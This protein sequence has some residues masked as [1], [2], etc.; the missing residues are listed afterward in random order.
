MFSN[1]WKSPYISLNSNLRTKAS[2]QFEIDLYKL[3]NN[4]VYGKSMQNVQQVCDVGLVLKYDNSYGVNYYISK[5]HFHD[6]IIFEENCVTIKMTRCKIILVKTII[7]CFSILDISTIQLYKFHYEY[8]TK[9]SNRTITY[10]LYR[11]RLSVL[12][13]FR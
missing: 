1:S 3:M 6:R 10:M 5:I 11:C 7:I 13:H 9:V 12:F 2:S 4:S 8:V